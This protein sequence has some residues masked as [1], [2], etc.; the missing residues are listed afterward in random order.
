MLPIDL[1]EHRCVLG[2]VVVIQLVQFCTIRIRS[3][4]RNL[5]I[6]RQDVQNAAVAACTIA[7]F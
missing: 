1:R 3:I 4:H 6:T 5:D 7:G 2:I